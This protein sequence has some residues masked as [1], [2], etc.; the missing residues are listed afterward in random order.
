MAEAGVARRILGEAREISLSA[1]NTSVAFTVRWL[2]AITVHGRFTEVAGTIRIPATGLEH[3]SVEVDVG[4]ASIRT[5]N[6]LRDLHLRGRTFLDATRFPLITFRAGDPACEGT[7]LLLLGALNVRGVSRPVE[8]ACRL[9]EPAHGRGT[10]SLLCAVGTTTLRRSDF[11]V[12]SPLGRLSRDPRF[13]LI[14][15]EVRVTATLR[16]SI[17]HTP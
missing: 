2:G 10:C 8:L 7:Q 11:A 14:G 16:A 17:L 4:T 13:R 5:G 3:A 15:D 6:R 9:D 12:G 1:R